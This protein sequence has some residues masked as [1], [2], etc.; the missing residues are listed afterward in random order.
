MKNIVFLFLVVNLF[1]TVQVISA[2][3][4]KQTALH[5]KNGNII[6]G[7]ILENHPDSIIKIQ[8]KCNDIFVFK[9]TEILSLNNPQKEQ[10]TNKE[11]P[12]LLGF[13]TGLAGFGGSFN[14]AV[15][16][17]ISGTYRFKERYYAGL[18]SGIEY[19]GIPLLPVA[20]EFQ[21]DVFKRNLT[22]YIYV[23]GGY[24]FALYPN[25]ETNNY[26]STYTGGLLLGGGVGI[27]KRFSSEFALTF[28]IGYRH[29]QT[30][31][32]RD[33]LTDDRWNTDY[34]RHYFYNRAVFR[35]GLVF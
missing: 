34:K 16:L 6:Y 18:S 9:H 23:R 7:K 13:D 20:G 5:L 21:A 8:N 32:T 1:L 25:E 10:N 12:F 24:G 4:H 29:Q 2:Q 31:E 28:S 17:L 35:I 15:S 19:F 27:K 22:P 11:L 33:Y 3:K 26:N 30:Y 14:P